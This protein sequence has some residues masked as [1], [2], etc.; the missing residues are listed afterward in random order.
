MYKILAFLIILITTTAFA[1]ITTVVPSG[2][3]TVDESGVMTI[4]ATRTFTTPIIVGDSYP[5]YVSTG[6]T[7]QGT[8]NIVIDGLSYSRYLYSPLAGTAATYTPVITSPPAAGKV[9]Y[10]ELVIGGGTNGSTIT[11]TNVDALGT[12]FATTVA[13]GKYSHYACMIPESGH[14]QCKIVSEGGT[15]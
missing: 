1:D 12:A 7:D 15:Y 2:D 8:K 10:I 13:T 9:R 5:T 14:A 11:W 6:T 4:P 3:V